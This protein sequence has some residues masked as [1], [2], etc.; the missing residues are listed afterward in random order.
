MKKTRLTAC[1]AGLSLFLCTLTPLYVQAQGKEKAC[2]ISDVEVFQN[3]KEADVEKELRDLLIQKLK[4]LKEIVVETAG[5]LKLN[6]TL[7]V[8]IVTCSTTG[9]SVYVMKNYDE[10]QIGSRVLPPSYDIYVTLAFL[11]STSESDMKKMADWSTCHIKSGSLG[12][13]TANC[14]PTVLEAERPPKG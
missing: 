4:S 14:I 8:R 9:D 1:V 11:Q 10:M 13:Q 2:A 7:S 6:V 12:K 5:S 3:L